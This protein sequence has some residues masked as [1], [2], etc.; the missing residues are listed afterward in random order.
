MHLLENFDLDTTVIKRV[1]FAF[2]GRRE[3]RLKIGMRSH[4]CNRCGFEAY[5]TFRQTDHNINAHVYEKITHI[6][7]LYIYKPYDDHIPNPNE[8]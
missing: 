7:I 8:Q 3:V 1:F 6:Y 5:H 4:I 2:F